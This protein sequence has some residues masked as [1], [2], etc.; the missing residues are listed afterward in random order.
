MVQHRTIL[1]GVG[2]QEEGVPYGRRTQRAPAVPEVHV[3]W[4]TAGLSCDG[5]SVSITAATQTLKKGGLLLGL[6]R[7]ELQQQQP[8]E[9]SGFV[10]QLMKLLIDVRQ[11]ARESKN[12]ATADAIRKGSTAIGV[13]RE[14]R[15]DGTLWRKE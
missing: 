12:F 2:T 1:G 7:P 8:A 9:S 3:L 6:F 13:T 15:A 5:D 10:D 4:L 14:D 11:Q